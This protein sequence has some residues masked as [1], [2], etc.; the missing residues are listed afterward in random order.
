MVIDASEYNLSKRVILEQVDS[1]TIGIVKLVK[2]RI[3]T[4]DTLRIIELVKQIKE[5]NPHINVVLICTENICSKSIAR[6]SENNI[7]IV[8]RRIT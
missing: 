2:S 4:K 3:I 5:I 7:K 6:L 1:D 8:T